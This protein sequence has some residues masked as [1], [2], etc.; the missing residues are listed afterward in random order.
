L[1]LVNVSDTFFSTGATCTII[2]VLLSPPGGQNNSVQQERFSSN[3]VSHDH[4]S[5]L[6]ID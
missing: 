2:N 4:M 5:D 6:L 1:R 3:S